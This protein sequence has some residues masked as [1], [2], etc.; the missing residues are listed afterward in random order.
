AVVIGIRAQ[1]GF[2]RF[3]PA[4]LSGPVLEDR[5]RQA[6]TRLGYPERPV[7]A[8]GAFYV[9]NDYLKWAGDRK[10]TDRWKELATGRTPG[11]GYWYRTSPAPLRAVGDASRPTDDDPPFRLEGMTLAYVDA[12][13]HLFEFA[14][15]PKQ[16]A[17]AAAAAPVN[18]QTVFDAVGWP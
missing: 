2:D 17:A 13:G 1:N 15:V 18:W 6:I 16:Q 14:R 11:F 12:R 9:G 10:G 7:D 3:V 8:Y 4:D 5:A